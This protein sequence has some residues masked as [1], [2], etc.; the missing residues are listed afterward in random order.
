MIDSDSLNGRHK[1]AMAMRKLRREWA[2][3]HMRLLCD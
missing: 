1:L 2:R 3:R